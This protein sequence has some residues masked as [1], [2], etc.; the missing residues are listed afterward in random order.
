MENWENNLTT[1]WTREITKILL[2]KIQSYTS[3]ALPSLFG[4]RGKAEPSTQS[5]GGWSPNRLSSLGSVSPFVL[6][7]QQFWQRIFSF[8]LFLFI[9][10]MFFFLNSPFFELIMLQLAPV[11]PDF[12]SSIQFFTQG[13]PH[14]FKLIG[15]NST[16]PSSHGTQDNKQ[17][18]FNHLL[19]YSKL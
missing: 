14:F 16:R 8:S 11:F 15:N 17:D 10:S 12:S 3:A 18:F 13:F 5:G 9:T 2:N 4:G 1:S 7:Y 6:L 19:S